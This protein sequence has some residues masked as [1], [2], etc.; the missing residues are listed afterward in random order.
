MKGENLEIKRFLR[1]KKAVTKTLCKPSRITVLIDESGDGALHPYT[2]AIAGKKTEDRFQFYLNGKPLESSD[3]ELVGFGDK[4]PDD[5]SLQDF[6]IDSG[7]GETEV[8]KVIDE[9]DLRSSAYLKCGQVTSTIVRQLLLLRA[10]KSESPVL[11]LNDPFLPFNGR[12]RGC[13]AE[14]LVEHATE[15]KKIILLVN[16]SFVP[17]VWIKNESISYI[18]VG[19]AAE[20]A[21]KKAEAKAQAQAELSAQVSA[22]AAGV[23]EGTTPAEQK[24]KKKGALDYV[25]PEHIVFAYR[26][27]VDWLFSPL[28]NMSSGMRD[29]SGV[30]MPI[31]LVF[32]LVVMAAVM[33]PDIGHYHQK[34]HDMSDNW[35]YEEY[36]K[37]QEANAKKRKAKFTKEVK[38][39]EVNSEENTQG[40]SEEPNLEE[41]G[42][43]DLDTSEANTEKTAHAAL[44]A[45]P[46][47][48]TKSSIEWLKLCDSEPVNACQTKKES[49]W[50][51]FR[52]Y[53]RSLPQ[54]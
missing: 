53:V 33:F 10:L 18:D 42:I 11:A 8:E 50:A 16:L 27:K 7:Y 22:A 41:I 38:R 9:Y 15:T 45:K 28:A 29:L 37:L 31:A 3:L 36:K 32:L 40:N 39:E 2:N 46:K 21:R 48:K 25:L 47:V 19:K 54:S 1:E 52:D 14:K 20:R 44:V 5:M 51:S 13:F 34:L 4:L 24:E 12:W 35:D 17:E 30:G 49:C 26:E 23:P 43:K 6:L